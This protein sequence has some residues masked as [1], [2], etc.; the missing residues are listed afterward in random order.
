MLGY[1]R[2]PGEARR[3]AESEHQQRLQ[4]LGRAADAG[5]EIHLW[6][7]RGATHKYAK[8]TQPDMWGLGWSLKGKSSTLQQFDLNSGK[9]YGLEE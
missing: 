7:E 5:I 2:Q 3:H 9:I 8:D 1:L 4:Q 6:R